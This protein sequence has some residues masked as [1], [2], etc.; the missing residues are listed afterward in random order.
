ML[1]QL[2][3]R[4]KYEGVVT[5]VHYNSD[6]KIAWVR[7]YER[8]GPTWSDH[9]LLDREKLIERLKAGKRFYAGRRVKF[10]A[11]EFE[12]SEPLHLVHTEAGD[13]LV[14]GDLKTSQDQLAGVPT[15]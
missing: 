2:F 12:V 14:T 3:S 5:A 6:G 15:I 8:R 10:Q 4:P 7:A 9:V 13:I 1:K 11:S